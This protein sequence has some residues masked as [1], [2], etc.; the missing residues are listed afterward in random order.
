VNP[1]PA[2]SIRYYNTSLEKGATSRCQE[3][4]VLCF[5]IDHD[6]FSSSAA[7]AAAAAA[8]PGRGQGP[9]RGQASGSESTSCKKYKIIQQ[10][11]RKKEQGQDARYFATQ[12]RCQV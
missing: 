10:I 1:P 7:A 6:I 5:F 2:K 8:P 12:S 9:G 11:I 3:L 4:C